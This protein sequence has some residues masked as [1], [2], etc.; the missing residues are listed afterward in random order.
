MLMEVDQNSEIRGGPAG[1]ALFSKILTKRHLPFKSVNCLRHWSFRRF[2]QIH[3]AGACSGLY[4]LPKSE[5]ST[6]AVEIKAT[7]GVNAVLVEGKLH[8]DLTRN[9]TRGT[10]SDGIQRH[11]VRAVERTLNDAGS[12]RAQDHDSHSVE[13]IGRGQGEP[14][15]NHGDRP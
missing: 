4:T 8:N 10:S 11:K 1:R 13:P 14:V 7:E 6:A 3:S 15:D 9:G 2:P 5:Y 12:R